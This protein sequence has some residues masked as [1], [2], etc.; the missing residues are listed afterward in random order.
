VI[1]LIG[2]E[3]KTGK[4]SFA[5]SF[6]KP[7]A[8]FEWDIGGYERAAIRVPAAERKLIRRT[9]YPTPL[10]AVVDKDILRHAKV[11]VGMKELWYQFITDY[12]NACSDPEVKTI[13]LDTWFQVWEANRLSVLQ[14]KQEAQLEPDGTLKKGE[15][16]RQALLQ[17]EYAEPNARMRNLMF[18]ARGMGKHLVLVTYDRD[19]YK[20][21]PDLDGRIVEVRTGKKIYAGWGETQKHCDIALWT[22][23]D[24]G[25][26]VA[27]IM[28]PGIAPLE[29]VGQVI[30]TN[31]FRALC[32]FLKLYG[33]EI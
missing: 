18:Y 2:G 20:P 30:P 31:T 27:R 4:T 29:S 1:A 5:L 12:H 13:V 16:L 22:E 33:V 6:P 9:K 10:Q 24:A 11:V 26:P 3:E 8:Y 7:L 23:I 25:S 28:L 15:K 19:E 14:E 32:D 21:Q 17:I